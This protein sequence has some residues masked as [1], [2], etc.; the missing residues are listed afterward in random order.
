MK[1]LDSAN[2]ETGTIDL[3]EQFKEE[4]REDLIKRA[5]VA[6]QANKRQKYGTDPRAGMKASAEL[7]RRRHNYRGSYGFGISRVPRKILSRRGTRFN[8]VGAVAPGTVGGRVAHPPKS[9]K[10][11]NQKVNVKE[12]RKAIRSALSASVDKEIVSSRGHKIP[13]TYPFILD[14]KTEEMSKT[15]DIVV[16]LKSLGFDKELERAS[17]KK[18]RAGKGK[19]RGRKYK[20]RTGPLIV[21]SKYCNLTKGAKNIPGVTVVS[22]KK[23]N[24]ECLAPGT[25]AGRATLYTKSAIEMMQK[26][27][28]FT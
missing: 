5:V 19:M 25:I 10:N 21:V 28:L 11:W 17:I 20:K 4:V 23:L 7:S 26:E 16:M 9:E 27:K 15:K 18:V 13:D 24:A 14:T 1:I 12:K 8:S 3:P 6:I 22:V 2:K